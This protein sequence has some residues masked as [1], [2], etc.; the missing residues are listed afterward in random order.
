[1]NDQE[2]LKKRVETAKNA[3][4]GLDPELKGI[5]F[6]TILDK[7]LCE[8]EPRKTSA[9]SNKKKSLAKVERG[10]K[11][12]SNE[13][14]EV[15]ELINSIDRTKYAGI[16]ALSSALDRSLYLLKIVGEHGKD[17]LTPSDIARI[18][19]EK[20]RIRT[21]SNAVSM[22]LMKAHDYVDRKGTSVGNAVTYRYFLMH[23]GDEYI[24]NKL[25]TAKDSDEK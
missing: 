6:K 11:K 2:E 15:K 13:N 3:V 12:T 20:F 1:M 9:R 4:V 22:A 16:H 7:L 8:G 17:G 5:A 10:L 23:T 18:L 24:K 21:T 14:E 19:T 25:S